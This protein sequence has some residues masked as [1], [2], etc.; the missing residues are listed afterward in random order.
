MKLSDYRKTSISEHYIQ[1]L[2]LRY[3]EQCAVAD[4]YWFAIPNAAR[5]S[6]AL[7]AKMRAEGMKSGVADICIM[8][9]Q[10]RT[11]WLE[12]K[13]AKGRQTDTQVEFQEIC[14]KLGHTYLLAHSLDEAIT[15]LK[16]FRVFR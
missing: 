8:L 9:A 14:R 13:K 6:M 7:A 3:L 11:I 4:A 5:R 16:P 1:V 15:V 12:L 10:G 2:V